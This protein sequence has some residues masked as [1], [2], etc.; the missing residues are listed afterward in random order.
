MKTRIILSLFLCA[1]L[2]GL[3][4]GAP[5]SNNLSQAQI[6]NMS[7]DSTL[8][9]IQTSEVGTG[10]GGG[11]ATAAAEYLS[12][13]DF[14]VAYTSATTITLSS[15]P[16]SI[17]D[18]AQ[19]VYVRVVPASGTAATY[20][21]GDGTNTIRYSGG[22]LTLSGTATPFTAGDVYEVGLNGVK[23]A[24][25]ATNNL[26]DIEEQ[27]PIWSR[28]TAVSTLVTAQD[29]TGSYAD[30]GAEI[31]MRGYDTLQ[32]FIEVDVNDSLN[33]DLQVLGLHTAAGTNYEIYG[34]SAV[35]LWSTVVP[36][37]DKVYEFDTG[38]IPY[39]QVQSIAGTV[40]STAG[41]LTIYIIK[42]FLR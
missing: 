7:Y 25:D 9:A 38:G 11:T 4:S 31:D 19:V 18:S 13:S 24:F 28:Y 10:S 29:L 34:V 5:Q 42:S 2:A 37:F 1:L 26:L 6:A 33:V 14:T 20:V 16:I 15:V 8:G 35:A 17:T 21:N 39:V 22:V 40:G 36:D 12:P 32:I 23:K 41:D 3:T 30:F 27:A